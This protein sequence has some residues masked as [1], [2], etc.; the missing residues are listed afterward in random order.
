M[1]LTEPKDIIYRAYYRVWNTTARD[2]RHPS[3]NVEYIYI[4]LWHLEYYYLNK[5]RFFWGGMRI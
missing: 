2:V 5:M 3:T 4:I 1:S